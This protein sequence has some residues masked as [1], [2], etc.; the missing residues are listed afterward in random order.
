M[1]KL[2]SFGLFAGIFVGQVTW[3]APATPS[4]KCSNKQIQLEVKPIETQYNGAQAVVTLSGIGQK[5]QSALAWVKTEGG[6]LYN[7]YTYK[8]LPNSFPS[9]EVI[10]MGSKISTRGGGACGRGSCDY[11]PGLYSYMAQLFLN[12]NEILLNC[13]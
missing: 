6:Y 4:F 8:F 13:F 11:Y 1:K 5:T 3:A 10:L 2:V 12:Q 9:K 7:K